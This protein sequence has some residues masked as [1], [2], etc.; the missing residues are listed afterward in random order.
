[1]EGV[2]PALAGY[3]RRWGWR[4]GWRDFT[5]A[6]VSL[7]VK[8]LV[9]F[10]DRDG[11]LTLK[12]TGQAAGADSA[13]PGG[14][15]LP[16]G[17]RA[18]LSWLDGSGGTVRVDRENGPSVVAALKAFKSAIEKENRH[19]FFRRNLGHFVAG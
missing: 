12:R 11:K 13:A 18:L 4:G 14:Q 6:A 16:S 7:A 2:S 17:E 5:A 3:I 10:D 9:L 8:G 1:P 19:R 15:P